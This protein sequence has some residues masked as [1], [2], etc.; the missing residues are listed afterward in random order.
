MAMPDTAP[1]PASAST[2]SSRKPPRSWRTALAATGA[3]LLAL[4]LLRRQLRP[5][6]ETA[7]AVKAV[8][9]QA[10]G[11]AFQGRIEQR[12][13]DEVGEIA[14]QLNRL[15]KRDNIPEPAAWARIMAQLPSTE[16]Q[17]LTDFVID[18]SGTAG[19]TRRQVES[20]LKSLLQAG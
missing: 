1:S 9:T 7:G 11:G 17:K 10:I 20:R 4:L 14:V 8:V 15:M 19:A 6:V 2:T 16:K 5:L 13:S 18:N 12:T 3:A